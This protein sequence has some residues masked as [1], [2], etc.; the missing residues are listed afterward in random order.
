MGG[1]SSRAAA[2]ASK[3]AAPAAEQ[4]VSGARVRAQ[5]SLDKLPETSAVRKDAELAEQFDQW[6]VAQEQR[7]DGSELEQESQRDDGLQKMMFKTMQK[8]EGQIT[9]REQLLP[10]YS[11]EL[12]KNLESQ[13]CRCHLM[14]AV[15]TSSSD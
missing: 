15:C 9:Y 14:V 5:A 7:L 8:P 13:V 1:A 3:R 11:G 12:A 2:R 6:R 4:A 10:M